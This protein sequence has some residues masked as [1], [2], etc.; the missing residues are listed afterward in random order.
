MV[1]VREVC[2]WIAI[3]LFSL[4]LSTCRS[5]GEGHKSAESGGETSTTVVKLPGVDT[6]QLTRRE[7]GEWS[8][9]V[10]ELPAPCPG[11]KGSVAACVQKKKPCA[12][13]KPAATF[14]VKQVRRGRTR[15]QGQSC[16]SKRFG[17]DQ[18]R[19][20]L[21]Q[22]SPAKGPD[23]ASV[24]IVEWADFQCQACARTAP[25]MAALIK[26]YPER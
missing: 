24:V 3:G 2:S 19:P 11:S 15:T 5:P 8:R 22:R 14:L 23:S 1:L 17:K 20:D 10:L 7:K 18:V 4:K 13:C 16:L 21:P 26:R 12:L 25:T 9:L 6:G